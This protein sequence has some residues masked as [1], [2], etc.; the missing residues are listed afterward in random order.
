MI[1]RR[2]SSAP[3]V[4]LLIAPRWHTGA[5]VALFVGVT[6]WGL[7]SEHQTGPRPPPAHRISAVYIPLLATE[8]GLFLFAWLAGLRRHRTR[9]RDVFG[10]SSP[11]VRSIAIDAGLALAGWALLTALEWAWRSDGR[12]AAMLPETATERIIW[13]AVSLTVAWCEEFVFRGY[14]QR[15]FEAL[16]RSATLAVA[17]Q[18]ALFGLIHAEQGWTAVTKIAIYGIGLGVL[19][20]ARRSLR[21]GLLL[22]AWTDLASGLLRI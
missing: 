15:Q 18:G 6:A 14:L 22:H 8:W 21:P 12:G 19:A 11:D 7:I 10:R 4:G 13:V 5:L 20:Q 16:F 1:P 9:V 2:G 17:L 3:P